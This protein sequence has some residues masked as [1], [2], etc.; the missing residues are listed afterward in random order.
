MK[1]ASHKRTNTVGFHFCDR[2]QVSKSRRQKAEWGL[3]GAADN[4]ELAFDGYRVSVLQDEKSFGD[5]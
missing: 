4:G 3:P 1:Q 2:A 5:E